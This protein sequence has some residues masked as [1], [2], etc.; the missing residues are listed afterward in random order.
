MPAFSA[1]PGTSARRWG[2]GA[3]KRALLLPDEVNG[4][5][6]GLG[7]PIVYERVVPATEADAPVRPAGTRRASEDGAGR[8]LP[9][10]SQDVR[11][12]HPFG[13]WP[14]RGGRHRGP[15][16]VG[17]AYRATLRDRLLD[18]WGHPSTSLSPGMRPLGRFPLLLGPWVID[19]GGGCFNALRLNAYSHANAD[20][21]GATTITA[22][23][24][25][26]V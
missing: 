14:R 5:A 12:A 16:R 20:L 25:A 6:V 21:Q 1:M 23:R 4:P 13:E 7:Y 26:A 10:N 3:S 2:S 17:H 9:T 8:A 22:V 19:L 24:V 11:S 18:D 15:I